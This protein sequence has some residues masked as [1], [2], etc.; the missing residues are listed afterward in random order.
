MGGGNCKRASFRFIN[1]TQILMASDKDYS[2]SGYDRGHL[3]NAED[4][5]LYTMI[6]SQ[7]H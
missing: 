2:K 4:F 7:L 5:A 6:E 1:D 3:A